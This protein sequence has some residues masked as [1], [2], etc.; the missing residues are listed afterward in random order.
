MII[1]KTNPCYSGDA[2]ERAFNN[3]L[4]VIFTHAMEKLPGK[5]ALVIKERFLRSYPWELTSY[6]DI[7]REL[8]CSHEQV[9]KLEAQGLNNL[10]ERLGFLAGIFDSPDIPNISERIRSVDRQCRPEACA[11][12]RL[13]PEQYAGMTPLQLNERKRQLKHK[14]YLRNKEHRL[15]ENK[16]RYKEDKAYYFWRT[17]RWRRKNI[18]S[19][20]TYQQRYHKQRVENMC[21][22]YIETLLVKDTGL[23]TQDIPRKLI[24]IKRQEITLRR[25][26]K[27]S[28]LN[29]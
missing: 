15:L 16:R 20:K 27:N 19:V 6:R 13:S 21:D 2:F 8:N 5:Q 1:S 11:T 28:G 4:G 3:E 9:R 18:K 17:D 12:N 29:D 22:G 7:A 25:L 23:A 10:R 24:T 14:W 26:I